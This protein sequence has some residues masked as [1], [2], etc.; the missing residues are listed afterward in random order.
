MAMKKLQ[1]GALVASIVLVAAAA[2]GAGSEEASDP[3]DDDED[4]SVDLLQ[5]VAKGRESLKTI[6]TVAAEIEQRVAS[7]V[8]DKDV[9]KTLCLGDKS[10]RIG[11]AVSSATDRVAGLEAAATSGNNERAV[12]DSAVLDALVDRA[13]ELGSEAN[14]CIGVE[15]GS[16]SGTSLEVTVDPEIP[17]GDLAVFRPQGRVSVA[18]PSVPPSPIPSPPPGYLRRI[19]DV[20]VPTSPTR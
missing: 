7:A 13:A 14:Q 6:E 1:L 18:L 5:L 9:I 20:P 12:H 2:V 8:G 11:V 19:L 15:Q 3:S 16:L 17:E 10:D 4:S